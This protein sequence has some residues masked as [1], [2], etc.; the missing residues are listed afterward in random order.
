MQRI[1]Q[2]LSSIKLTIILFIIIAVS[3]LI[4]TFII[5]EQPQDILKSK[6]GDFLYSIFK[7]LSFFD[8]YH[9]WWFISMLVLF[10]LNIIVCSVN[11]FSPLYKQVFKPSVEVDDKYLENLKNSTKI[12]LSTSKDKFKSSLIGY[13]KKK[14]Y[15]IKEREDTLL[16]YKGSWSR[17][18]VL[19]VHLSFL[20]IL[21]GALIGNLFGFKGYIE[22][23]EGSCVGSF[24]LR[25]SD[26][27]VPLGFMVFLK[28]FTVEFYEN[29]NIPKSFISEVEIK[30]S[31]SSE[32]ILTEKIEVNHPFFYRGIKL[33]QSSYGKSGNIKDIAIQISKNNIE[34]SKINTSLNKEETIKNTNYKIKVLYFIPDFALDEKMQ[35]F[36]KSEEPNNPAIFVQLIE[37]N[38]KIREFWI[39]QKFP[40][41][42]KLKEV[43][44]DFRF[45]DFKQ[46]FYSGLQV[47]N[48]PGIPLVYSGCILILIGLFLSLC[49]YYRKIWFKFKDDI[50]I[51]AGISNKNSFSFSEEFQ[52]IISEIKL[53][54]L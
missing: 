14:G 50:F 42:H 26:K 29:K 52:K 1:F 27:Q 44:F 6:Y 9:S 15:K 17:F 48:D 10:S 34:I 54:N 21:T 37:P 5:Q 33:Y 23:E 19:I 24:Y 36:S 40:D 25:N 46:N 38:G 43:A 13:L 12:K 16:S 31:C 39:F 22:I 30:D 47:V 20:L 41:F 18:S 7:F 2:K 35:I 32:P 28:K 11:I 49:F 51:V 8:L 45:L 4:G 53:F 3:S